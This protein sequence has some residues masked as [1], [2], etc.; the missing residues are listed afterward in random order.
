MAISP[1][2]LYPSRV[3]D[4]DGAY[5]Y[6]KALNVQNG[7]EGTGTPLEAEWV[8]DLWGSQQALLAEAGI[9]PNGQPDSVGNSQYLEAL[10]KIQSD[11]S[12]ESIAAV[13]KAQGYNNVFFFEDGFTYTESNDVGID[14]DG[15]SWIYVGAGAP[16]KVV[17][18]GT[19]PSAP[20]YEQV[21][22]NTV[23]T[24][25]D[26]DEYS[27]INE[28]IASSDTCVYLTKN[29]TLPS[30]ITIPKGKKVIV[31]NGG[32]FTMT[33]TSF[34][35]NGEIEAP[36][37]H[38]FLYNGALNNSRI[39]GKPQTE[40]WLSDWFGVIP[41]GVTDYVATGR[42][43]ALPL[44]SKNT[45]CTVVFTKGLFK[46]GIDN[47]LSNTTFRMESGAEFAG[48]VHAAINN[49][50][51]TNPDLNPKNVTW[52]GKV[53]ALTRFGSYHCDGLTVDEVH[54][55]DDAANSQFGYAGGVHLYK[56]TKNF[57]CKKMTIEASKRN[58]AFGLDS[59]DSLLP[60]GCHIGHLEI[61]TSD[62]VGVY[63]RAKNSRID[64]INIRTWGAGNASDDDLSLGLPGE[65][66]PAIVAK[67]YGF[68]AR[69]CSGMSIGVLTINGVNYGDLAEHATLLKGGGCTIGSL[70]TRNAPKKGLKQ[71]SGDHV[72]NKIDIRTSGAGGIEQLAGSLTGDLLIS[73]FNSGAG[74]IGNKGSLDISLNFRV[75]KTNQNTQGSSATSLKFACDEWESTFNGAGNVNLTLTSPHG[76]IDVIRTQ[77]TANTAGGLVI[78]GGTVRFTY[79][80]D[81]TNDGSATQYAS[82]VNAGSN[83]KCTGAL[84]QGSN[85]QALRL[86]NVTDSNFDSVKI[87]NGDGAGIASS[88]LS[89]VS[90]TNSKN[91]LSTNIV[92]GTIEEFN[93]SGVS[94]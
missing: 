50:G 76:K 2:N 25:K 29:Y 20:D 86:V 51:V 43:F 73:S 18:A 33:N 77:S 82:F 70:E 78:S 11:K 38:V 64:S 88:G 93:N 85:G 5:P 41:D 9:A 87:P 4:G 57:S 39:T 68:F 49:S 66:D 72:I 67:V 58:F 37:K 61:I 60:E 21:V 6:G 17:P 89:G 55:K 27:D 30:N 22:Y 16:N 94:S 34:V 48:V 24:I 81:S 14:T 63:L 52:K 83:K 10:K 75:I 36:R 59:D 71:I 46:C 90:F 56:D 53:T 1:K 23:T 26:L 19:V 42:M 3:I 13:Y 47:N 8:N 54:I 12:R 45:G 28:W 74:Y 91:N 35:W 62:V 80:H 44:F 15:N 40:E 65:V 69:D 79:S 31:L 84:I 7:V 32:T 92:S